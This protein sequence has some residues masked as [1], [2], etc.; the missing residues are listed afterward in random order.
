MKV[1]DQVCDQRQTKRLLELG[2]T[3][4]SAFAWV[5]G[6]EEP[7]RADGYDWEQFPG[8]KDEYHAPAYTTAEL[9]VMLPEKM[10]NGDVEEDYLMTYKMKDAYGEAGTQFFILPMILELEQQKFRTEA[11]TRAAMLIYL[12]E[13]KMI[14]AEE[15]NARLTQ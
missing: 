13:K 12:L 1:E 10:P 3:A 8:Y 4:S 14:T 7:K 6:C 11:Q 15:V 5:D 2:I 9:G